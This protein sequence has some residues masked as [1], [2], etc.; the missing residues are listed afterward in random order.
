MRASL[1]AQSQL[2]RCG[3]ARHSIFIFSG[4]TGVVLDGGGAGFS[5]AT[6]GATVALAFTATRGVALR[7]AAFPRGGLLATCSE[8]LGLGAADAGGTGGTV[9]GSPRRVTSGGGGLAATA[10]GWGSASAAE[11]LA[12]G[13]GSAECVRLSA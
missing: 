11:V 6:V 5:V 2:G 3:C 12:S 7:T 9:F 8:A 1:L 13:I 10:G 4:F